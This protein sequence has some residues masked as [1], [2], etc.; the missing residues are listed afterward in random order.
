MWRKKVAQS[1]TLDQA[2]DWTQDLLVSRQRSYQ[3]RQPRTHDFYTWAFTL[4]VCTA[5]SCPSNTLRHCLVFTSHSFSVLYNNTSNIRLDCK[6]DI[7]FERNKKRCDEC[8]PCVSL[9]NYIEPATSPGRFVFTPTSRWRTLTIA[10]TEIHTSKNIK[11]KQ[12]LKK[13]GKVGMTSFE[14][15]TSYTGANMHYQYIDQS[16]CYQHSTFYCM[17]IQSSHKS[18]PDPNVNPY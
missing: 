2:G 12:K 13:W 17:S 5:S 1:S 8:Y 14:L 15:R 16:F 11:K 10:Q 9:K 18:N 7:G 3:L 6:I 4:T